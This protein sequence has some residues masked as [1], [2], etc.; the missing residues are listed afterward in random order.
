[1]INDSINTEF[2][3]RLEE[4]ISLRACQSSK[5]M[6]TITYREIKNL[7]KSYVDLCAGKVTLSDLYNS[8]ILSNE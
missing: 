5:K 1:M 2:R 8:G 4:L 3:L 6:K 7:R